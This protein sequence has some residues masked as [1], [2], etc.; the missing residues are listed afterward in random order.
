[1]SRNATNNFNLSLSPVACDEADGHTWQFVDDSFSH[2]F[3][4]EKVQYF[5]CRHC[6]A[7]RE[8]DYFDDYD[9]D[10]PANLWPEEN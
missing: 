5:R 9:I 3:G 7:T 1:M 2:E 4:T 6:S 8:A 10:E